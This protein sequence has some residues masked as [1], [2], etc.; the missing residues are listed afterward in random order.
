MPPALAGVI[1]ENTG[2][3]GDIDKIEIGTI[4]SLLDIHQYL[5]EGLYDFAGQ[6]RKHNISKSGFRFA[7]AFGVNNTLAFSSHG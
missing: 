1:P 5:F 7:T 4:K 2:G 3:Y 6:I